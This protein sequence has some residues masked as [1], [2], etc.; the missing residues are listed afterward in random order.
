MSKLQAITLDLRAESGKLRAEL[1]KANL[2]VRNWATGNQKHV[3]NTDRLFASSASTISTAWVAA[4]GAVAGTGA[5]FRSALQEFSRLEQSQLKAAA[6]LKA[7]DFSAGRTAAQLDSQARSVANN[8]LA[9]VQGVRDAQ[10]VLLTFRSV[11][12]STFDRAIELSQDLASVMGGDIVGATKQLAK[13]LEDPTKGLTAMTRSGVS[14]SDAEQ[15]VI[16][17][18]HQT[19]RIAEAQGMILDKLAQQVGGA[20]TGEA[21]GLAGRADSLSQRWEELLE[22]LV[23]TN[24]AGAIASKSLER[25][26][27]AT[28]AIT[29]GLESFDNTSLIVKRE[30]LA[31]LH[32]EYTRL[33]E[34]VS[35][36]AGREEKALNGV[37]GYNRLVE[38]RRAIASEIAAIQNEEV[39]RQKSLMREQEEAEAKAADERKRVERERVAEKARLDQE[40][41]DKELARQAEHDARK[42]EMAKVQAQRERE[43][44]QQESAQIFDLQQERFRRMR[45]AAM[46][47]RGEDEALEQLRFQDE[48]TRLAE[49]MQRL[50][51]RGM[52]TAE[53]EAQFRQAAEDAEAVHQSRMTDLKLQAFEKEAEIA[54]AKWKIAEDAVAIGAALFK[55]D[56]KAHRLLLAASKA[57]AL[58][59]SLISLQQAIAKANALGFPA[60][61]PAITQATSIGAG[62]IATLKGINVSGIAHGGLGYVPKEST[63]LLDKGERVLSP[64]QNKDLTNFMA[65]GGNGTVVNIHNYSGQQVEQRQNGREIDIIIGRAKDAI[66]DDVTRG[67]GLAKTFESTYSLN[68]RGVA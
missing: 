39:E 31:E 47:A 65:G 4:A 33:S 43:A 41:K 68:R 50:R 61:I 64:G 48:Q 15:K 35:A 28:G 3:T 40:L 36:Y 21:G 45:E 27:A 18:L 13:A 29:K 60:N 20:G 8:T 55:E 22:Q 26:A 9:S 11:Q 7:T 34:A 1:Q 42:L 62:A 10:A 38:K 6:L 58:Q 5:L 16:K 44:Y 53:V 52:L 19:G 17:A 51:E 2:A 32:A 23:N 12:G 63:Y 14:F 66:R 49:D 57:A 67:V 30:K 46:A 37:A 59:Q 56:S 24:G 54:K 25:L